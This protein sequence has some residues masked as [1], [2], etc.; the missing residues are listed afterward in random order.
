MSKDD[1]NTAIIIAVVLVV[2][3]I[4]LVVIGGYLWQLI[5]PG[6]K[7]TTNSIGLFVKIN[8]TNYNFAVPK[9]STASSSNG[10]T[11]TPA[12]QLPAGYTYNFTVPA[13]Y[14]AGSNGVTGIVDQAILRDANNQGLNSNTILTQ[15]DGFIS[16]PILGTKATI[17]AGNAGD[18]L[19]L[20]FWEYPASNRQIFLC[21]RRYFAETDPRSCWDLDRLVVGNEIFLSRGDST[22]RYV[23]TSVN[24][25][26]NVGNFMYKTASP[27]D[28]QIITSYPLVSGS[29][30]LVI[31]AAPQ[32]AAN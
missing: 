3:T 5:Y 14:S 10:N 7:S 2:C 24:T 21:Q 4:S 16:I 1:R 18:E 12:F 29:D 32:A 17:Y 28:L 9:L 23:V 30:R 6:L 20:G 31:T 22:F 26:T 27:L 11:Q 8:T 13:G 25:L 19:T 15:P